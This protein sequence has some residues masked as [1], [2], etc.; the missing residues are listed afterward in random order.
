MRQLVIRTG[1]QSGVDRA[2]LDV[3][4]AKRIPYTGWCPRGGW[5]EDF[6]T[7]P[8]LLAVYPYLTETPS[9]QPEQR[10]AWNVRDSHASLAIA[11]EDNLDMSKGTQFAAVC[12]QVIFMRPWYV[13]ALASPEAA[14]DA[15]EWVSRINA[16]IEPQAFVLNLG[17][18]RESECPGIYAAAVEFLNQVTELLLRPIAHH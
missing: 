2:G 18:P 8:G 4:I 11:G 16:V 12:A 3:A 10:S 7:S 1:G 5:A 17:G 13:A 6:T 15:A 9:P 14:R